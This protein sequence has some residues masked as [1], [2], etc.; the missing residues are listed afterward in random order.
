MILA[1]HAPES[2]KQGILHYVTCSSQGAARFRSR[3]GRIQD[4]EQR[5]LVEVLHHI[6]PII[7][8]WPYAP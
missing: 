7:N 5:N 6:K 2:L 3:P 4:G 1:L 8:T